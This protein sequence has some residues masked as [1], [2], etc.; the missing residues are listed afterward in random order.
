MAKSAAF[1][2]QILGLAFLF[3]A[4]QPMKAALPWPAIAI[5]AVIYLFGIRFISNWL[6]SAIQRRAP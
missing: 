3:W 2:F 1:A 6:Q 5:L 4:A